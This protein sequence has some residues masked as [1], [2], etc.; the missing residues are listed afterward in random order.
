MISKPTV[1][2]LGAGA[3]QHLEYPVGL[4]L[5]NNVISI[6]PNIFKELHA[7]KDIQDFQLHLS[8]YGCNSID[9][10]LEKN[11]QF[12]D[13]GKSLIAYSLKKHE[14]ENRLFP[15]HNAGWYHYLFNR[16]LVP[17]VS[18]FL[19]N[20][21][22]IITF[23]YD[24]SLEVYLHNVVKCHYSISTEESLN[25]IKGINMIHL[26]G[27][28]GEYPQIPYKHDSHVNS[29]SAIS[30]EG[31]S[32]FKQITD[33]IKIIHEI[34]EK[35]D[36]FCSPEFELSNKAL[37]EAAKI[38]FLGFGFHEDNIRRFRFF[39]EDALRNREVYSTS[40]GFFAPMQKKELVLR[41]S[42]YGLTEQILSHYNT[43]CN[44][45]FNYVGILE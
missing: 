39:S 13:I 33:S 29:S 31:A 22:T 40:H 17:S 28:L 10:F 25:I 27:I 30:P 9:E 42:K 7:E 15:S 18:Q 12:I 26:H 11:R 5:L 36:N 35:G 21:I 32:L 44:T 41:I 19:D 1:L 3:S 23:N 2:I 6:R 16:M 38:Y 8:R 14:G 43:S 34:S 20:K 45:F 4:E 37:Q 24:R